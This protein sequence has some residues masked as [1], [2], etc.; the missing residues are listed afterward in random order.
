[1]PPCAGPH[2]PGSE[3]P[4]PCCGFTR[5]TDPHGSRS[6]V[7][8]RR[9]CQEAE[10]GPQDKAAP[11]APRNNRLSDEPSLPVSQ[12]CVALWT[13]P[14]SVHSPE[15]SRLSWAPPLRTRPTFQVSSRAAASWVLPPAARPAAR[16]GRGARAERRVPVLASSSE[17][18]PEAVSR[19]WAAG[20]EGP[21]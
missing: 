3:A 13:A 2:L 4:R 7:P 5:Q 17:A 11:A 16:G 19:G 6:S 9:D 12:A 20:K 14:V 18:R 15:L 10:E 1:M 21:H 8:R